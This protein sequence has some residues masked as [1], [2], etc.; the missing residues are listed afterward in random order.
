M[1]VLRGEALQRCRYEE[2]TNQPS[3]PKKQSSAAAPRA[4]RRSPHTTLTPTFSK[5]MVYV[6]SK[7]QVISEPHMVSESFV[8]GMDLS[9]CCCRGRMRPPSRS[10]TSER[11]WPFGSIC[12]SSFRCGGQGSYEVLGCE[13]GFLLKVTAL[14]LLASP[15]HS[16]FLVKSQNYIL[17]NTAFLS[18]SRGAGM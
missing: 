12:A 7:P 14:M 16:G 18:G 3:N 8:L 13:V 4:R 6:S 9:T 5:S 11:S 2:E 10:S 17:S 1:P 15:L